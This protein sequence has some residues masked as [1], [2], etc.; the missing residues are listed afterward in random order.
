MRCAVFTATP[1]GTKTALRVRA[2]LDASVDIFGKAGQEMPAGVRVYERLAPQ[3]AAAFRQYDALIFIMATGIAVRMIAGSL[4]S[5]LEDPAVLV[6]DEE[7]QHVISLLSGHIGGANELTRELAASL[8]A[9][10]VIT[11]ATDVQKKLAVDVA[12]ARLALRP[13]PKEQIKR[14]NSA[15]LDD[16]AIRYVIDENLARASFYKKRLDDMGLTALFGRELPPKGGLTAFITADE[17]VRREDVICLVPR[18]LVAGIGCRRGT[19]MS[20]IRVALEATLTKIGRSIADVSLLAS[21]EAKADEAGLLAL[22]AKLKRDI[23]FHSNEKMQ[24]TIDAYGLSE[25]PFVKKNIGIGNV[26][27]AAALASVPAGR[28]ALAKT[29]F[30]KVTVALVWEK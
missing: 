6:L 12:A 25:S 13:S 19:E 21:T 8:G 28:L 4:K 11:T 17:S 30:E 23:R 18:R 7:A 10:P 3:V 16:A 29:R 2:S 15:V 22:S 9:D 26:A 27:E 24:E 1:R 5:K 20:E 14:F